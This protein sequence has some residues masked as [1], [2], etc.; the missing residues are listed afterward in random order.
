M[1]LNF[2]LLQQVQKEEELFGRLRGVK[3]GPPSGQPAKAG[4]LTQE[5]E[6]KFV[7]RLFVCGNGTSP[8]AVSFAGTSPSDGCS[9]VC[10]R[11][12]AALART[13][14]G[15]V[16]IVD[17]NY[18]SP[19]LHSSFGV[20]LHPGLAECLNEAGAVRRF[21]HQVSRSNLWVIPVG[22]SVSAY[23]QP[24][25]QERLRLRIA[26]LRN[27]FDYVLVD[28]PCLGLYA[29]A[30]VLG[31]TTDGVV[32]VVKANA[33]KRETMRNALEMLKGANV[34]V[35]GVVLNSR[36]FPIPETIYRRL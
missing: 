14:S 35:L 21:A 36:T 29:D 12:S 26:E 5:E 17:A 9:W 30:V 25:A 22:L 6:S 31:Q 19:S 2:E 23:N 20:S 1:S 10:V 11:V 33:T 27:E 13:V 3:G 34:P 32:V 7:Q 8:K 15:S 28:S 16:C 4:P 18:R 24:S